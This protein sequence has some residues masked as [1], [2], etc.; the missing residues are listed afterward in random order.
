MKDTILTYLRKYYPFA[1]ILEYDT[2]EEVKDM[3][4]ND[5]KGSRVMH[6]F[7]LFLQSLPW[8]C[9]LGFVVSFIPSVNIDYSFFMPFINKQISLAGIIKIVSI[10]G[11]IGFGTNRLA[12]QMLFRPLDKRP[13]WGQGLI[14]AQKDRIIYALA[15]GMHDHIL[16]P[17]LIRKRLENTGLIDRINNILIDGTSGI[18]QDQA[19]R[20]ELKKIIFDSLEEYINQQKVKK[21]F[22]DLIDQ[23]VESNV[24]GVPKF[25]LRTFKRLNPADYEAVI[26][27]V[28]ENIPEISLDILH[29]IE[30]EM[31]RWVAF[32]RIQR[33]VT[34]EFIMSVLT[35][36][37]EKIDIPSLLRGQMSHFDE[38]RLE[39]MVREATNEQLLYIQ[40]LGALLGMMGGML[41]WQPELMTLVYIILFGIL[42]IVDLIIYRLNNS[43]IEN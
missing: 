19:L 14:P 28:I 1:H 41:I 6:F 40:Y 31:N 13:I 30:D 37:L 7:I 27:K 23:R 32:I 34:S 29:K 2:E 4:F 39:K 25:L 36:T 18:M 24:E 10:S 33:S 5:Y 12:I 17:D 16:N 22:L 15:N 43:R 26:H 35:E 8:L 42:Y 20:A 11:L 38:E 9:G 3:R 21:E